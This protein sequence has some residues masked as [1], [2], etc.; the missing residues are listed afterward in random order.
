MTGLKFALREDADS[1]V[2]AANTDTG[3]V[4]EVWQLNER[5]LPL[6]RVFQ[7]PSIQ[8]PP[9]DQH[10]NTVVGDTVLCQK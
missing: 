9:H 4:V 7:P 1:L 3:G 2:V 10:F 8:S 5:P 6:H